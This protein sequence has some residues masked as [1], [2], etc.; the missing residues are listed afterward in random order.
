MNRD[1][2]AAVVDEVAAQI[3]ESQA[4][5]AVD[6]RGISVSQVAELRAQLREADASLRVIKNR[7]TARAVDKAGAENLK[8]FLEGPTAFT[9]IRGDAAAAAKALATFKKEHELLEFKGGTLDGEPL[10]V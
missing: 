5:I 9:F 2:K 3:E 8:G 6:Y 1:E 7:L 10:S 4:I